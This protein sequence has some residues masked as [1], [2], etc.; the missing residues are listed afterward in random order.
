MPAQPNLPVLHAIR[1]QRVVLDAELARLYGVS[2]SAFNQ[3]IKRNA[4]RF[5]RDFAFRLTRAEAANLK[6]HAVTSSCEVPAPVR[7]G[8]GGVRKPPW[9]FTEHGAI[10][11]AMVLRSSRA[12]AMSVYVV[13]AFVRLREEALTH[14]VILRRLAQI[15]RRLLEHD[16]V[17]RDVIGRLAPLLAPAEEPPR[18]R[19]GFHQGNR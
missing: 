9:V 18:R 4:Q 11:A 7:N 8:H 3:A 6:S 15:D 5:P 16:V 13:R 10:M 2:T 19:I 1:D 14:A 12:M 17:L